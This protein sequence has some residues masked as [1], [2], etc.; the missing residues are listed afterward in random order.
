MAISA[1]ASYQPLSA[2][3]WNI[4]GLRRNLFSLVNILHTWQ[5]SLAFLSEPLAYQCDLQ[6]M[7]QYLEPQYCFSLNSEDIYDPE[8]PLY[9]SKSKGGT[10]VLW[11]KWIDP[12]VKVI[13][14]N[15]TAFLPI[16]LSLPGTRPAVHVSLYLPTHGQ[17]SAFVSELANLKNCLECLNET[18][19]YPDIYIRGDGNVNAKNVNRVNLLES[20]I[21]NMN[22][23][24]TVINHKTYHHFVGQ[25]QFDSNLDILLQSKVVKKENV[26]KIL[27]KNEDQDMNSHHDA[28]ISVFSTTPSQ[29]EPPSSN[30]VPAPRLDHTRSKILWS[31]QGIAA[32]SEL[33]QTHLKRIRSTWLKP[34]CQASM[35]MLLQLTN[36]IL[37]RAAKLTNKSKELGKPAL[38]KK[39]KIKIPAEIRKAK[40]K[41]R[42]ANKKF[43]SH[44]GPETKAKLN[45]CRKLYHRTVRTTTLLAD[46]ERDTNLYNIMGSNPAKV[47]RFIKSLKNTNNAAIAELT[48]GKKSYDG[49]KVADGF[50]DSMTSLKKVDYD[51]LKSEPRLSE[52]FIDYDIIKKLCQD[53]QGI[54]AMGLV[55]A[56]ELLRKMKKDVKD[57]YSITAQHYI[58]AGQEGL[59]HICDVINGILADLRNAEL[60]ELNTAHALIYYKGHSKD[61]TSDRSYRNISS[62]PFPAKILDMY[63]RELYGDLWQEQQ[64]ETQY[65]GI[66]S[67]HELASL[68]VT[69]VVQY[70]LYV[71]KQPVYLL[72]LDA[73]SAFDR[74]LRQVLVSEL[75]RAHMPPA[76]VHLID[77]RL[78]NRRTVYEWEGEVMGPAH[79]TTGFEQGGVNSSEYYKLY[80][81][82]QLT[83]AQKSL[84]GADIGS[85]GIAAVGQAD[86]VMLM[87]TSLY[88]LQLLVSLTEEYCTKYRVSLEPTKTRLLVYARPED[89]FIVDHAL[90]T[91]QVMI[92]STPVEVARE[93]EHV[94]VL[95]SANGNLPHIM[96]RVAMHK[97]ALH[98][99]LPAGLARKHR[100][101]PAAS[102]KVNQLYATPVLLS[103]VA[104]LVLSQADINIIEGHYMRTLQR[105]MRL[106]DKTPRALVCFIA[107]SLPATAILHQ[108]QMSLFAM[109]CYMRNNPLF[110]HAQ[111][112]LT[113]TRVNK[114]SWFIQVRDICLRYGLPHPLQ[115]LE[116]PPPREKLKK[117]VK[118]KITEYWQNI[119]AQ[120]AESKPSLCYFS[121]HMHSLTTP[122]PMWSAAGSNSFEISKCT[123]LARMASGRYRTE[124]LSRFWTENRQGLCLAPTC[125]SVVGDLEHMLIHCPALHTA[126]L[127]LLEMW[128]DRTA[129]LPPLHTYI[130]QILS[131]PPPTIMR[132]ILD[133]SAL[134]PIV[135]LYQR[136]GKCVLDIVFYITRTLAYG[137]HRKKLIILGKWPY[138]VRNENC[139]Q[140]KKEYLTKTFVA[141]DPETG[142]PEP[143]DSPGAACDA[144][145]DVPD[146][147]PGVGCDADQQR[148]LYVPPS[149]DFVIAYPSS[150]PSGLLYQCEGQVAPH[151][152]TS[153]YE[154]EVALCAQQEHRAGQHDWAQHERGVG[155]SGLCGP[156]R[157][158]G[159]DNEDDRFYC[160]TGCN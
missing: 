120:E 81:N 83:M 70:S 150:R 45:Q 61:K 145:P 98:A 54:P 30:L 53:Q 79:D 130:M 136:Y 135:E 151:L 76:A 128:R 131:S 33:V 122:H 26:V 121:P 47:F 24:Q 17:D 95:R 147:P 138:S 140:N 58:H 56:K 148:G 14:V 104:S 48:V 22:L 97:K 114:H 139:H 89:S 69:E 25:G 112:T 9:K 101:S 13:P 34:D 159:R 5:P 60:E 31:D 80:N 12:Y 23:N 4:E 43:K 19:D 68:L 55:K 94:G 144:G 8:L 46:L 92:R 15:T 123:I 146:A 124:A 38:L 11:Q 133:P 152:Q 16:L 113:H 59:Q 75:Y 28:I 96:N 127:N 141:G 29:V 67:S 137:L 49:K 107:G 42:K 78:A 157:G 1:K 85:Q 6:T 86:D 119:L 160:P 106:H 52:K 71:S 44:P 27:C 110:C 129:V 87:S 40:N 66:G 100:G 84:L 117:L 103:G 63:I 65:Q 73:Q 90:N 39:P 116:D 111:Y 77:Q 72:A 57:H 134:P 115:L 82:E 153:E 118:L 18:C 132:F 64:A 143:D 3:S 21:R 105:L 36:M 93:A 91:Q 149:Y 156:N 102:L 74:C 7:Q 10:M 125:D 158:G 108:R 2:L 62:C 88:N 51:I 99:L 41:L 155:C 32:F 50:Y 126:R 142:H 20:F 35:A 109:V 154:H 37:E